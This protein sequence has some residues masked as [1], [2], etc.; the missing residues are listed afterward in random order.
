MTQDTVLDMK[1]VEL[2]EMDPEKQPMAAED[3]ESPVGGEKNGVM[4]V[5]EDEE[6]GS[7]A[8]KFTGLS[9]E[10]LLRVAGTPG[11]VRVRWALLIL[12]WLGWAGMLAG[13]VVIIVQAPRCRPLPA[14]EWW[15][16]GPL[17]QI[18][19]PATFQDG[20][21][22]DGIGDLAGIQQRL[23]L[24]STLKVKGLVIGPLHVTTKDDPSGT[25][26]KDIDPKYGNIDGFKNLLE[27]ARKKSI[28]IVLDLTPN[29][30]GED[31][32]FNEELK[33]SDSVLVTQIQDAM[34]F[35]FEHGVG[36][37][38]LSGFENILNPG[39]LLPELNNITANHSTE[40]KA[41]VLLISSVE[42]VSSDIL[43]ILNDSSSGILSTSY[44]LGKGNESDGTIGERVRQYK[45]VTGEEDKILWAIRP[46]LG[47]MASV[48]KE[49][50]LRVYQLLLFT[51]PGTPLTLYG[52]EIGLK[53][54]PGQPAHGTYMQW[55]YGKNH[56]FSE[57]SV[58]EANPLNANVTFEAQEGN[59]ASLLNLYKRLSELRGKER[60]L[61]HGNFTLL[62][63]DDRAL[64][65]ARIWDQNE[66]Y[67]TVV[68]FAE[69]ETEVSVPHEHIPEQCSVVLSSDS[70]RKEGS[71]VS[72]RR[73]KVA[74]GEALLLKYPY[75]P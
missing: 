52:D 28:Q 21:G 54:L 8:V 36:G 50:L 57:G 49:N 55:N 53:D 34:T 59:K 6:G 23:D 38:Y 48:V 12:F 70:E 35:W 13:A 75:S 40:G 68:N 19:D 30:R 16:K 58:R 26:L 41:R 60:S 69:V 25:V 56:G 42:S 71:S 63:H 14:M 39:E 33:K 51:L 5:K 61:L 65:F 2:N 20:E 64:A 3:G 31:V 67:V 66:R 22:N 72:V 10:E 1:D 62:H 17:Y 43:G 32:W 7:R 73:L 29:Y 15:N 24:L 18:G 37:I 9:K 46:R 47:H 4:K 45:N 74:A 11:W 44:L 27:A